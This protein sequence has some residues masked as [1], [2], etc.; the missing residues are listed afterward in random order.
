[1]IEELFDAAAA[2]GALLILY[3]GTEDISLLRATDA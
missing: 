3:Q 2:G 1:M